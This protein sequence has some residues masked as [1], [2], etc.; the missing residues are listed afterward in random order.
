MSANFSSMVGEFMTATIPKY[1]STLAKINY[2]NGHPD[3]L[4]RGDFRMTP[5]NTARKESR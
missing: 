3:M 2:H 4:R 1:C 5:C